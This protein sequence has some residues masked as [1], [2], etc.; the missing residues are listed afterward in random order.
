MDETQ[1]P[2]PPAW[3]EAAH[4]WA[5]YVVAAL[6]LITLISHTLLPIAERFEAW[7]KTTPATWDD[8][9]ARRAVEILGWLVGASAFVWSLLP[10]LAVGRPGPK[11]AGPK[12]PAGGR[13]PPLPVLLVLLVAVTSSASGCG[14]GA[15]GVQADL[16]A[17]G[18][19]LWTE[20]DTALV[21][22]RAHELD[23]VLERA[24]G[25]CGSD[26]CSEERAAHYR[27]EL[28]A[29][30]ARWAP[31]MECRDT[32]P[33]ALRSWIDGIDAARVAQSSGISLELLARLGGR[34]ALDY[35]AF[36]A[37]VN[38]RAPEDPHL[39]PLPAE[40]EAL[41]GQLAQATAARTAGGE[42]GA[43]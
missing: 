3:L 4:Q 19:I 1:I 22:V 13:P 38:A 5:P 39:P 12:P 17:A 18:G 37:C 21:Q 7:A 35:V 23:A 33:A 8:A 9:A 34:F 2:L 11:D 31:A 28:A 10:R 26:G 20:A 25:E 29:A 43:R 24:R 42:D 15:L 36:V 27:A 16:V 6:A 14:A 30:E 32:V 40:L 41:A